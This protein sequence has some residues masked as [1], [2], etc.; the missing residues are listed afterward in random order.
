[1]NSDEEKNLVYAPILR[2]AIETLSLL[3]ISGEHAM[4]ADE[5]FL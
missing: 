2:E 5:G 4:L 3:H 1:M